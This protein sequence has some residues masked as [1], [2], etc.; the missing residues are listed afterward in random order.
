MITYMIKQISQT[1]EA[2]ETLA[3]E[4]PGVRRTGGATLNLIEILRWRDAKHLWDYSQECRACILR[5]L[6]PHLSHLHRS[7]NIQG[8]LSFS[9]GRSQRVNRGRVLARPRI[10]ATTRLLSL[11]RPKCLCRLWGTF[12]ACVVLI[13][14]LPHGFGAL[15]FGGL[16]SSSAFGDRRQVDRQATMGTRA[17]TASCWEDEFRGNIFAHQSLELGH[18]R[19]SLLALQVFRC[20]R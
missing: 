4:V 19:T 5:S 9:Q 20:L 6:G 18:T 12:E 8:L 15:M 2:H 10:Q 1:G 17:G 11:L 7:L 14:L 13:I 16:D 3:R